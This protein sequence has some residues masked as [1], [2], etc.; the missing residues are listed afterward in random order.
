[1]KILHFSTA[2]NEG[3]SARSAYRIH[4]GL[5]KRGHTSRMLVGK[6]VTEDFDIAL[7]AGNK[8]G[9]YIDLFVDRYNR[10][11]GQQ[12]LLVPS[13]KKLLRNPWLRDSDI[14]QL[15]NTHGG[16][17]S[18]T[19]LP[20]LSKRA[21]IV[22]RL[23][24]MWPMTPHAAYT[25]GCECYKKGPDACVCGLDFYP[26]IGRDTKRMLWEVKEEIY[27]KCKIT[28]VAPSNW[29]A[30]CVRESILLSRFPVHIIPNGIDLH[31]FYPQNR[32]EAR[33]KFGIAQDVKVILFSAHGLDKNPRKGSEIL[34]DALN[35]LG[36]QKNTLLLLVGK[37]GESFQNRIPIPMKLFGYINDKN[38]LAEIYSAA[39]ILV[40]PSVVEN[41]PNN[42][43]EALACG[44]PAVVF[45]TGGMCDAVIHEQTGYL[46]KHGDVDDFAKG[47]KLLLEDGEL[48]EKLGQGSLT[49][50]REKFNSE[51]EIA[52]FEKLYEKVIGNL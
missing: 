20:E 51:K 21:P 1:M 29:L 30:T 5:R 45:D 19:L 11:R 37:G 38:L 16:Y 25:Y 41:L 35:R 24:D 36:P 42:V 50:A 44:L 17:F 33:R 32:N 23:S 52:S 31:I 7:V 28:F 9:R 39:D 2:D 4:T 3:G 14:I 8:L 47:M 49:L 6:K 34:I 40:A 12:Y 13:S 18:H 46:A 15:Y 48:R 27:K 10:L 22:W 43:L 26:K